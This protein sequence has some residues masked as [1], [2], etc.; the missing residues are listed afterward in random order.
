[1]INQQF[2]F[3]EGGFHAE[4]SVVRTAGRRRLVRG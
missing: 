4:T 2:L 1:M 3:L